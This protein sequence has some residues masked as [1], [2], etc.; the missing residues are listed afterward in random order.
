MLNSDLLFELQRKLEPTLR[1]GD[2]TRCE[3]VLAKRLAALPNSPFHIVLD[4]AIANAPRDVAAYCDDIFRRESKRFKIGAAYAE[5]NGFDINPDGWFFEMFAFEGYGGHKDLDWLSD[6]RSGNYAPFTITG[7]EPLQKAYASPAFQDEH[8][9]DAI[10]TT[11]LLVVVKFQELIQRSAPLMKGLRFPLLATA[12]DFDFKSEVRPGDGR[13][14]IRRRNKV[15]GTNVGAVKGTQLEW[16]VNFWKT[17]GTQLF[18]AGKSCVPFSFPGPQNAVVSELLS[19][20][21]R[22]LDLDKCRVTP[23]FSGENPR[24]GT[25]TSVTDTALARLGVSVRSDW[26]GPV[27]QLDGPICPAGRIGPIRFTR[28][29]GAS[30]RPSI[31]GTFSTIAFSKNQRHGPDPTRRRGTVATRARQSSAYRGVAD[32]GNPA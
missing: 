25:R 32:G 6:W 13:G 3:D 28:K 11:D 16:H 17:K 14:G 23:P 27:V 29:L 7:L 4:L 18:D 15:S 19:Q 20:T 5:M 10:T 1:S 22:S 31:A 9:R 12:H 21:P 26:T 24:A 2:L 30:F 8:L